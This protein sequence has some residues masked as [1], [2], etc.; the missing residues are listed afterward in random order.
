MEFYNE[1]PFTKAL[2][3]TLALSLISALRTANRICT[4][5]RNFRASALCT[6]IALMGATLASSS[7]TAQEDSKIVIAAKSFPESRLLAEIM[8]QLIEAKTDLKVEREFGLGGTM[9]C[10]S[11]INSAE[12]DI[13][14]EYTGTGLLSILQEE[15]GD[16]RS[17]EVIYQR[18]SEAFA[19]QYQLAWLGRF[20]FNNT[21]VLAAH[22]SLGLEKI[23][24]LSRLQETLRVRFQHEFLDR[25]DGYPGL[26]QKYDLDFKDVQGMEHGLA[27]LALNKHQIDLMDAYAT[28][29]MLKKYD[30]SLLADDKNLFPPYDAAPLIR[31]QTLEQH[32]QL[33]GL[34]AQLD[35]LISQAKMVDM[36]Y[37]V[38]QNRPVEQIASEFLVGAAL[39]D[40][41]EANSARRG[42]LRPFM[43]MLGQHL[44]LTLT[45]TVLATIVG[46]FLGLLVARHPDRLSGPVMGVVG[47]LQ[48]IPS[49]AM[50]ALMIPLLGIGSVPAIAALFL[51]ALLPIVRNT[52]TG[53]SSV[54][55]ELKDAGKGMGMT[56]E[57][58]L[59]QL[60]LP[61]ATKTIMAGIRTALVISVGTATLGAF[62][63]AGGFGDPINMGLQQNNNTLIL[64][65]A[66]PAALLAL[67]CDFLMAMLE[68]RVGP[69][70]L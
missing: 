7:A 9:V 17:S 48:T 60:E 57:Q 43:K 36:N 32:P 2:L 45:A 54:P 62:I 26:Q 11:A 66:I 33:R 12:V 5:K 3:C 6:S 44:F 24:D 4:Q 28:D 31:Q 14:P 19:E 16:D 53:I 58:L 15:L 68:K 22:P 27:Y 10:F 13:Y 29:G 8:A 41:S 55:A 35:G 1:M 20:G 50:L 64:S 59:L 63:G 34:L 46:V 69:R 30:V 70:G 47:I 52:Y 38:I 61:L 49:L 18:V 67:F 37:Q 25:G 39:I 42:S 23:S 21:Y 65:G 56:P 40:A 51:Y